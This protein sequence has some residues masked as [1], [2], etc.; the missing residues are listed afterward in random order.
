MEARDTDCSLPNHEILAKGLVHMDGGSN[1]KV[2]G[3]GDRHHL[4]CTVIR[5]GEAMAWQ[6]AV[7]REVVKTL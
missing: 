1:R 7:F 6:G 4:I 5:K 3:F 2:K